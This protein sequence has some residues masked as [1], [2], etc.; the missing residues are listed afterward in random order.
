MEIRGNYNVFTDRLG[1]IIK[2]SDKTNVKLLEET[3][4]DIKNVD[5]LHF[6]LDSKNYTKTSLTYD[7]ENLTLVLIHYFHNKIIPTNNIIWKTR[8]AWDWVWPGSA[9]ITNSNGE[10]HFIK[11]WFESI[12]NNEGQL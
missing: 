2:D 3:L 12:L 6:R 5:G 10:L 1:K 11:I 7:P 9:E 4:L 8:P